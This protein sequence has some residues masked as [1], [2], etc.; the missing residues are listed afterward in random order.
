MVNRI[1]PIPKNYYKQIFSFGGGKKID[2]KILAEKIFQ[3]PIK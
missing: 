2:V 3:F 1:S